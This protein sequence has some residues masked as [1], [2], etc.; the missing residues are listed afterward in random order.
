MLSQTFRLH[1]D[2]NSLSEPPVSE[3][4][5]PAPIPYHYTYIYDRGT[6]RYY[7][8]ALLSSDFL[9]FDLIKLIKLINFFR[10]IKLVKLFKF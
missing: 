4:L 8:V 1:L 7:F 2:K 3:K 9:S 5:D 6:F 10:L